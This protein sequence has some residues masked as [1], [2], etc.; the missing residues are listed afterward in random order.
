M[1]LHARSGTLPPIRRNHA[2]ANDPESTVNTPSPSSALRELRTH[3][4][5]PKVALALAAIGAVLALM[6]PFGT[7]DVMAW[8]PRIA[9]W[10]IV[11]A[12]TYAIG[13]GLGVF[14]APRLH[15]AFT[16]TIARTALA[17]INSAVITAVVFGLNY[18][19]FALRPTVLDVAIVFG[20]TLLISFLIELLP[21]GPS[22]TAPPDPPAILDR[23]PLDKRG[24]LVALSVEDHY[25]RIRTTR[26]E[27]MVLLRL[28]DAIREVGDTPGLRVHRSHW[29]ATA[30]ITAATRRGD[31]AV[32]SMTKGQD[33]PV[34][35][36]QMATI[37]DAGLLPR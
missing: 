21:N 17:L 22:E 9:Y 26:G 27:E 20:I 3:F 11:P 34:S 2:Y 25:V 36:S 10:L 13:Y 37:R 24:A 4:S 5:N 8:G 6:G 7:G 19:V 18:L 31:G 28:S 29:V 35:R 33:I 23:L 1:S 12:V 16:A 15:G 14:L 32:L 30:Q